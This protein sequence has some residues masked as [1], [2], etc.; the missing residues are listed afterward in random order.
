MR[1][2]LL[3]CCALNLVFELYQETDKGLDNTMWQLT[4]EKYIYSIY[5]QGKLYEVTDYSRSD[6]PNGGITVTVKR[7]G[8][9]NSCELSSLDSLKRTGIY[10][11]E[12]D[13]SDFTDKETVDIN[14]HNACGELSYSIE[15]ED[16]LMT[17]YYNSR[18]QYAT[19]RKVNTLPKNV[20][21]FLKKKG[22]KLR[23]EAAELKRSTQPIKTQH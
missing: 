4:T 11:F 5:S 15:D 1:Y 6:Y 16:T 10:Y 18:Q 7:Y 12:V 8:F 20:R 22:I 13:T 17:I 2:L 14:I 9:Y 3:I 23:K 19:Y 21:A